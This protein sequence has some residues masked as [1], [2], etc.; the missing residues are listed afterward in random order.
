MK[1]NVK[2]CILFTLIVLVFTSTTFAASKSKKAKSA[3]ARAIR[4]GSI[5]IGSQTYSAV[6]DANRDGYPEL[7]LADHISNMLKIYTYK[8]GKVVLIVAY[9]CEAW[10]TSYDTSR[11]VF[12]IGGDSDTW[13]R[14]EYKLK[15]CSLIHSG[16]YIWKRSK[17]YS[18]GRYVKIKNGKETEISKSAFMKK[19]ITKNALKKRTRRGLLKIL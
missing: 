1:K 3:Y 9:G 14:D 5:S 18:S 12:Y 11:R 6:S 15:K 8:N 16:T 2:K 10:A 13:F 17:D 19:E 7:I 4:N